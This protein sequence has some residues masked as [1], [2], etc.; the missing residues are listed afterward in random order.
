MRAPPG[1]R[2][3]GRR[4][5]YRPCYRAGTHRT[6][7]NNEPPWEGPLTWTGR[8]EKAPDGQGSTE[9]VRLIIRRSEVQV[10]PAPQTNVQVTGHS[11]FPETHWSLCWRG[12]KG[13]KRRASGGL[14]SIIS[15][16]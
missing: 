7:Q 12:Q 16:E 13:G 3:Q 4:S 1:K 9:A 10:L 15:G 11:Q 8:R 5:C 6:T 14:V 2:C